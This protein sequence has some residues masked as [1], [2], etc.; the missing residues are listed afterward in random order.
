[1]DPLWTRRRFVRTAGSLSALATQHPMLRWATAQEG[2]PPPSSQAHSPEITSGKMVPLLFE[3]TARP[4]R[5]TPER[6]GF[7]IRN[8]SEFFNRPLYGPNIPFRVDGGDLPEFSL[9]LPGH[10][11][12]LRLGLA[13]GEQAKWLFAFETVIARYVEGRLEYELRDALLGANGVLHLE[14][15]T[16]GA[17]FAVQARGSS[18]PADLSLTFAFGGVSGRKGQRNGDIG[19]ESEP[20][21]QFFQLRPE[22]AAN[23]QWTLRGTEA[24]VVSGK[25]KLVVHTPRNAALKLGRAADWNAGWQ[26]LW[27]N[28]ETSPAQPVLLG[29]IALGDAPLLLAVHAVE[30]VVQPPKPAS[31]A[32]TPADFASRREDLAK[33]ASAMHWETG[34]A[35]LDSMAPALCMAADAIWDEAQGCV[36]HG[37]VAWRNALAGWRGPYALDVLG[38]HNRMRRH[39]QR[40]L[41]KQDK[42]PV[43]NGSGGTYG[44]KGFMDIQP[45][46]GAPDKGSH[47]AR[48]ENLLHSNGDLGH[49]HYDMNLVF[50]DAL[51]RHLRWTGDMEF[52]RTAWPAL[53]AHA[54]WER[55]LF[56]RNYAAEGE[57][58]AP[59]YEAYAAI[60]A[61]DNLQYNGGGAA[62]SSAYNV[63]LN[64]NLA[65][66]A[67]QLHLAAEVAAS[68]DAEAD[69]IVRAMRTHLWMPERGAF[70]ESRDWMG[71]RTQ[72][73]SPAWWTVYHALDCEFA[74]AEEAWLMAT[75]RLHAIPKVPVHGP[76][77]P[78]DAGWQIACSDWQPYV[79]S[80]TL[81]VTAENLHTALALFQAGMADDGYALLRG[82]LLDAGFRGLCPGNFPMSLQMDPHRQESQR[83]FG[84]PI[85]C[86]ARAITE[87]LWGVRPDLLREE[88]RLAPQLPLD[89]T[90]A[91]LKHPELQ[92]TYTRDGNHEHWKITPRLQKAATLHLRLRARTT[93]LPTV[94]VNGKPVHGRFD[95]DAI[96]EPRLLLGPLPAQE[97]FDIALH[98]HGDTPRKAPAA[99]HLAAGQPIVWPA[100]IDSSHLD[101]PLGCLTRRVPGKY[102]IF[103]QQQYGACR[104]RL[105]IELAFAEPKNAPTVAAATRYEPIALET[106]FNGHA[107]EI[108]TRD[109]SRPR[110][111]LTSL[112][113]PNGL[114]GGWANFDVHAEI[115][116]AGLRNAGGMLRLDKDVR[117]RTPQGEAKNC[118]Y[119]SQWAIDSPR[120]K[121][122][123]DGT[124]RSLHLLLACTTFPQATWSRH[125]TV[126]VH[127]TDGHS[128]A[129]GLR[130]PR[131]WWPVEQDYMLD[132]YLFRL[133]DDPAR[134]LPMRVDLRTGKPRTL[135]VE[136]LR[137][138]PQRGVPGG[139]AF[140]LDIPLDP[141]RTL[142]SLDLHCE[143]YGVVLG[144]LGATLGRG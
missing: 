64:R 132:D 122:P 111:G 100:G 131:N 112:N 142:A 120:L 139:S 62:H 80:L 2:I 56:R 37:A 137:G 50:F 65:Q 144:L 23:N 45:A 86:A 106:C 11:G 94:T 129:T 13:K 115:D 1:M 73:E 57:P 66:L 14:V 9:Y 63:F 22:E 124:A 16:V 109:Y 108:F 114:L 25:F 134:S 75:D 53:E 52:A 101:D 140:V 28:D 33:T 83:D 77:V 82:T 84:D 60:W 68:Y 123:L 7:F 110:S 97:T 79:W 21:T 119:L 59:L 17:G 39:L 8:G 136:N 88:L 18:L 69:A 47:D 116:D 117:F 32:V 3:N 36:M 38:Q 141:E 128:E 74:S 46:T 44:S 43:T 125:A 138:K 20:V 135:T 15:L 19:C 99:I 126:T 127:Y 71:E 121:L 143:L 54:A 105:P 96:G 6:V 133:G 40:W 91:A 35:Y 89:W 93:E 102:T 12:N 87:G 67:R 90:R 113:L 48:T 76:G 34:D 103:A 61:S 42:S 51:L 24:E 72:A 70:A 92:L 55:R 31:G 81:L 85:G 30:G 78:A 5:Y 41:A 118:C 26:K 49:N 58:E 104:Y 95:Q 130:S 98:W 4:M 10:G 27:G 107:R 29:N